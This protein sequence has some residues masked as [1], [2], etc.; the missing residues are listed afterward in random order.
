MQIDC[1]FLEATL[2]IARTLLQN[3]IDRNTVMK[4]TDMTKYDPV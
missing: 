1:G 3:G 2:R 4:I